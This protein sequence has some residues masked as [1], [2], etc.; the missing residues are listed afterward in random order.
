MRKSRAGSLKGVMGCGAL[1]IIL[2]MA[3]NNYSTEL[4]KQGRYVPVK[5]IRKLQ[6]CLDGSTVKK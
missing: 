3:M 6:F 1:R 4:I 5:N 2:S